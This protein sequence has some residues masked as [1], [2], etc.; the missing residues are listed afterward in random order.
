MADKNPVISVIL[1]CLNEEDAL[2]LCLDKIKRVIEKNNY[3]AE[4]IV[5][6]NGSTDSSSAIAL[7]KKAKLVHEKEKGYG[8]AYLKGISTAMGKYLFLADPDGTYDFEEMPKF[9]SHLDNGF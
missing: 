8:A 3:D 7:E 4:I 6:D 9:I 1:P 5:V 2:G